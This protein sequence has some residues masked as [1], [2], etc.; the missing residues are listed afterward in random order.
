[1]AYGEI[2]WSRDHP[3]QNFINDD[4]TKIALTTAPLRLKQLSTKTLL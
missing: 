2:E 1:M 4:E 3:N